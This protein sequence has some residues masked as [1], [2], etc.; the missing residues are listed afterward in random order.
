MS[1]AIVCRFCGRDVEPVVAHKRAERVLASENKRTEFD[2]LKD[3][4]PGSFEAVWEAAAQIDPWPKF[5]IPALR[6]A[7]KA[8]DKGASAPDAVDELMRPWL[9]R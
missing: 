4:Y 9:G 2:F 1:A 5:P 6:A 7:C 3:E 8:V